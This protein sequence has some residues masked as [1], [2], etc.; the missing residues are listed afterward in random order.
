MEPRARRAAVLRRDSKSQPGVVW[1]VGALIAV[2]GVS[3]VS[4]CFVSVGHFADD[5]C[6]LVRDMGGNDGVEVATASTRST[7]VDRPAALFGERSNSHAS[8]GLQDPFFDTV[9]VHH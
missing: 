5:F 8:T 1:L 3:E 7:S 2:C 9:H 6:F 4:S